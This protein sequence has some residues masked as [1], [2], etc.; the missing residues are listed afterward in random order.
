MTASNLQEVELH[1]IQASSNQS[2]KYNSNF[3]YKDVFDKFIYI[4]ALLGITDDCDSTFFFVT[5]IDI[6]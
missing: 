2:H 1:V 3:M 4:T 5:S 6:L